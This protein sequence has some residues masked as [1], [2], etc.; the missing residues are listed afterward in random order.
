MVYAIVLTI[1]RPFAGKLAD[2][3]NEGAV[4]IPA[5]IIAVIALAVLSVSTGYVG[6]M[7]SAV[8]YGIGF[9][10]AQPTLQTATVNL[11]APTKKGWPTL[12]F[13]PPWIWGS[14]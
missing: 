13:S 12:P 10:S 5:V 14:A 4:V 2:R 8:L 1:T 7:C 9:G 3:Y 11:V 6:V